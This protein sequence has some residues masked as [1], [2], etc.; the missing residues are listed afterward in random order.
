MKKR[1]VFLVSLVMTLFVGC[2]D[3]QIAA[4]NGK[5]VQKASVA[6]QKGKYDKCLKYLNE[7][8]KAE[9]TGAWILLGECYQQGL[10]VERDLDEAAFCYY[11]AAEEEAS[12]I[13]KLKEL[14]DSGNEDAQMLLGHCY[15]VGK[16]VEEDKGKAVS[17]Y[18]KAPKYNLTYL[19]D[20]LQR[21]IDDVDELDDT[22]EDYSDDV[23][24]TVTQAPEFPGGVA[25]LLDLIAKNCEYPEYC[26]E[27][28]IMGTVLI[29]FVVEADGKVSNTSVKVSC[30]PLLDNESLRVV[31]EQPLWKPGVLDGE[32]VRC[33]FQIPLRFAM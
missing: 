5:W 29:M 30:F 16:G 12:A 19:I 28:E 24:M 15:Q 2:L 9:E 4:Q 10:G 8:V 14:A 27:R 20:A 7:G 13:G 21:E 25:A 23:Y 6:M 32:K 22:E 1:N 11:M 17:C 26:R 3:A 18:K 33:Y 31:G